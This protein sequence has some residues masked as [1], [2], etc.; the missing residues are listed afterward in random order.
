[1]DLFESEESSDSAKK[2][3]NINVKCIK[4]DPRIILQDRIEV[5]ISR[6]QKEKFV[7]NMLRVQYDEHLNDGPQSSLPDQGIRGE[8]D[9]APKKMAEA[10]AFVDHDIDSKS[11]HDDDDVIEAEPQR[12]P[13]SSVLESFLM[14]FLD[15]I[16]EFYMKTKERAEYIHKHDSDFDHV[17]VIPNQSKFSRFRRRRYK[18][19]EKF[20]VY[21]SE[22][23]SMKSYKSKKQLVLT[24]SHFLKIL[25]A[26][27]GLFA[28]PPLKS[29]NFNKAAVTFD[30]CWA[31]KTQ[32][33]AKPIGFEDLYL[34]QEQLIKQ[35]VESLDS[36]TVTHHHEKASSEINITPELT[37]PLHELSA[38]NINLNKLNLSRHSHHN[39]PA[40][41]FPPPTQQLESWIRTH[42]N[43]PPGHLAYIRLSLPSDSKCPGLLSSMCH[44]PGLQLDF[45]FRGLER[46]TGRC[47]GVSLWCGY[48]GQEDGE[49]CILTTPERLISDSD[50]SERGSEGSGDSEYGRQMRFLKMTRT[51]E[52]ERKLRRVNLFSEDSY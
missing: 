32:R 6:L 44:G 24:L 23:S 49:E 51:E 48:N 12:Q 52:T 36:P 45:D 19:D 29:T 22:E 10:L 26:R 7:S 41:C 21:Q 31:E 33:L 2:V 9:V 25:A 27:T 28:T 18:L 1:M 11:D 4:E 46:G 37:P 16:Y 13:D 3:I 47:E 42:R 34:K 17:N 38:T 20:R 5:L 50:G 14:E 40:F 30:G 35:E 43:L 8:T 15:A 39:Y